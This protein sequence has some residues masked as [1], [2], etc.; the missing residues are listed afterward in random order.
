[1]AKRCGY[2]RL[3]NHN[4]SNCEAKKNLVIDIRKHVGVQ[5]RD[6]SELLVKNGYGIGAL[7]HAYSYEAGQEVACL[8]T[9]ESLDSI[10]RITPVDYYNVKYSKR[11]QARFYDVSGNSARSA[12]EHATYY[13]RPEFYFYVTPMQVGLRPVAALVHVSDLKVGPNN[14]KHKDS[15][16]STWEHYCSLL[17]PSND[18]YI[19]EEALN[20]PFL[21]TE[22]LG[23]NWISPLY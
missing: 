11:T 1:M 13:L 22:R 15:N 18:G 17:A 9:Q 19:S 7:V 23:G 14:N 8:V 20:K 16:R 12:D 4:A 3:Y 5:R 2:C 21:L 10:S 6:L